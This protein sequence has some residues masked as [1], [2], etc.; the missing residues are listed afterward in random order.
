MIRKRWLS[1]A[2]LVGV[3]AVAGVG[4]P[5]VVTNPLTKTMLQ[6]STF[7][8]TLAGQWDF[9]GKFSIPHSATPP[10]GDCDTAGEI[11][12]LYF[13]TDA[14]SGQ[15]VFG[16]EGIGG[17]VQQGGSGGGGS[18]GS[19]T[20][21]F[22][23]AFADGVAATT[24]RSD[25]TLKY[26]DSVMSSPSN[27]LWTATDSLG[28]ITMTS[29]GSIR[30]VTGGTVQLVDDTAIT[31]ALSNTTG[32]TLST[33]SG[34]V[35]VGNAAGGNVTPN[36]DN[37]GNLGTAALTWASMR[38][39]SAI[40]DS[41]ISVSGTSSFGG[42][43]T[44]NDSATFNSDVF[45]NASMSPLTDGTYELGEVGTPAR[46][47]TGA[48]ALGISIGDNATAF[49][50]HLRS[51]SSSNYTADRIFTFDTGD[52]DMTLKMRSGTATIDFASLA[53]GRCETSGTTITATGAADGDGIALGVGN[54][55]L[56]ASG[57]T[58]FAWVSSTNTVS[59]KHCCHDNSAGAGAACDPGSATF[60]AS[61]LND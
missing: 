30:F 56:N 1:L 21:A 7:L 2:V 43:A 36:T 27:L 34:N 17:W 46:W 52:R 53:V 48:F 15:R 54:A 5:Q 57:S 13:D 55:A 18:F 9:A 19:P 41:S 49:N 60:R 23:T 4:Y 16:C 47:N 26:P 3:L 29:S 25:A 8:A 22:G 31:G 40:F 45:I 37:R 12:R 35:V 61:V 14:P 32:C 42:A 24:I 38:V 6:S 11:G 28:S 51:N 44:F 33:S 10:V 59:V 39:T 20:I 50:M 58:F